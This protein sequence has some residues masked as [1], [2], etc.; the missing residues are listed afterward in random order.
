MR[1]FLVTKLDV[2]NF[3]AKNSVRF[4]RVMFVL[5]ELVISGIQCTC[6]S[7]RVF[8]CQTLNYLITVIRL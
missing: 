5:T 8:V 7:P 4:N 3:G 1:A 6:Y 2:N